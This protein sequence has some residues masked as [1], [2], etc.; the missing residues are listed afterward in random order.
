MKLL[1]IS[2]VPIVPPNTGGKVRI[3]QIAN[4][5][6][7]H[8]HVTLVAPVYIGAKGGVGTKHGLND[9]NFSA[10]SDL[11]YLPCHCAPPTVVKRLHSFCSRWPY[12]TALRYRQELGKSVQQA[13]QTNRYDLIYCHFIQTLP[14]VDQS[15]L[16]IIV[17]QQNVD[18]IYWHRQC[19]NQERNLFQRWLAKHNLRKTVRYETSRLPQISSIVS[20]SECDRRATKEY[21]DGVTAHFLVA[22]NGVDLAQYRP[23][24]KKRKTNQL[25]LGFFGSM[26]LKSN[27]DAAFQLI[28]QILPIVQQ[29]LQEVE[30]SVLLIGRN[31]PQHLRQVA[32]S[33]PE[34]RISLTGTVTDVLPHLHCEH[35]RI[36]L[37]RWC[38]T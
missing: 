32:Q 2:P 35:S 21:A 30:V 6:A 17:D 28:S 9:E 11:L 10:D 29:R 19:Q 14:Y 15:D 22:P 38:G 5:L 18:R 24:N 33:N 20:V 36:A 34:R 25:V 3:W 16:P 31:P 23:S 7:R 37:T 13:L 1:M 26:D 4:G 12:H 27:Q 8:H